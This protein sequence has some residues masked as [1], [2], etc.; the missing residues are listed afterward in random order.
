MASSK[1]DPAKENPVDNK[2][3]LEN[4][5]GLEMEK[6]MLK[7]QNSDLETEKQEIKQQ[8]EQDSEKHAQEVQNLQEQLDKL[9][10]ENEKLQAD[11]TALQQ[12]NRENLRKLNETTVSDEQVTQLT[13][14]RDNAIMEGKKWMAENLKLESKVKSL[15]DQVEKLKKEAG[16]IVL[17]PFVLKYLE[18]LAQKLSAKYKKEVTPAQILEDYTIRYNLTEHWTKWFH[19]WVMDDKDAVEIAREINPEIKSIEDLK[20]AFNIK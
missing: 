16:G 13:Q 6:E 12:E 4:I 15:S 14:E 8:R 17:Q 1:T 18:R 5:K 11:N 3:L 2:T 9:K 10:S 7:K 19:E 20:T